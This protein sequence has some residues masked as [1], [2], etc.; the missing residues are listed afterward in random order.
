MSPYASR[1]EVF[2]EAVGLWPIH[3]IFVA[4]AIPLAL[5]DQAS[6]RLPDAIVLP[7]WAATAGYLTAFSW[8]VA[9]Q[10]SWM[11]A[12]A[13]MAATFFVLWVM[14]E[15]PG[16]PLGFGDVKLGGLIALHLGWYG[17]DLAI[18]ALVVAFIGGGA[19]VVAVW[20]LTRKGGEEEI[21]F[22]PW[23]I[24]GF[25][26]ALVGHRMLPLSVGTI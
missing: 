17:A 12:F 7:L 6:H 5:I 24:I 22:G 10:E 26:L 19:W 18:V 15:F 20:L 2:W 1:V 13:V 4:A 8:M 16:Q 21:A 3:L 9:D 25:Y 23:L 14:A 11:R